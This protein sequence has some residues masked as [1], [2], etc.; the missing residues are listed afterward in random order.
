MKVSERKKVVEITFELWNKV[1]QM[2][3]WSETKID[4]F[5]KKV[6]MDLN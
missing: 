6:H 2:D 1:E 3:V 4:H 5:L